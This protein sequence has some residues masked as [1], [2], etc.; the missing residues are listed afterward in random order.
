MKVL[1]TILSLIIFISCK[2]KSIDLEEV[3]PGGCNSDF[4]ITSSSA[5]LQSDGYWHV[6]HVGPNYFT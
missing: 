1:I 3:C 6:K 2:K 5:S 4:I